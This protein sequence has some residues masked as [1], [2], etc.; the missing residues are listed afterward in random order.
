MVV[1]KLFVLI[2]I[3]SVSGLNYVNRNTTK[4]QNPVYMNHFAVHIPYGQGSADSIAVKHG[5][6]NKGQVSVFLNFNENH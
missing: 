1:L 3:T 4:R 5:F 6:V 2:T